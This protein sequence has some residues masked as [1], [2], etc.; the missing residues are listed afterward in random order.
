MREPL[1]AAESQGRQSRRY[2]AIALVALLV[3]G[4]SS[5]AFANGASK[6]LTVTATV[7]NTCQIAAAPVQVSNGLLM[8][9]GSASQSRFGLSCSQALPP[10]T[11]IGTRPPQVRPVDS[12][13]LAAAAEL[14]HEDGKPVIITLHF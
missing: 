12:K 7:V 2:A 13:E 9:D 1:Q 5:T 8:R 10:L 4:G 6:T 14:A 11:Q 3:V